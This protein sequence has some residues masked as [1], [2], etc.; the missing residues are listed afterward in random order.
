M[1]P[2]D[3]AVWFA[4]SV[5]P[6]EPALRAFLSRR[7][8]SLPDHDDLV[9][10]TYVRLLRVSDPRRL[11]HAR[12]FF[13]TI[14]RSSSA[15]AACCSPLLRKKANRE[16]GGEERTPRRG[17]HQ[18]AAEA[19]TGCSLL[20]S[21]QSRRDPGWHRNGTQN[22]SG[23]TKQDAAGE[24]YW[25][26]GP[27]SSYPVVLHRLDR[28]RLARRDGGACALG[29]GEVTPRRAGEHSLA[30]PALALVMSRR[31]NAGTAPPT[32]RPRPPF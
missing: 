26:G 14:A 7:F 22:Y 21:A 32:G 20:Q 9:Q 12:A 31:S 11:A 18:V 13:F 17:D 15:R 29:S 4:Q 6:H 25:S 1:S 2:S 30:G 27:A 24:R 28:E 23:A 5:R 10:E 8:S 3:Q 19:R 16:D